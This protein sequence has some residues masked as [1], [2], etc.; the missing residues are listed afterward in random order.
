MKFCEISLDIQFSF[1]LLH[2]TQLSYN[3]SFSLYFEFSYFLAVGRG[4]KEHSFFCQDLSD[5][6]PLL[7]PIAMDIEDNLYQPFLGAFS[8]K[9]SFH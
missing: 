6:A 5:Q 4:F 2:L 9:I 7:V 1:L 3:W 8:R